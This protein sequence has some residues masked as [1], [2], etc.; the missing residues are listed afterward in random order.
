MP[1]IR[2]LLRV[3]SRVRFGIG[4]PG[5]L[6]TQLRQPSIEQLVSKDLSNEN[7]RICRPRCYRFGLSREGGRSD[8]HDEVNRRINAVIDCRDSCRLGRRHLGRS[9]FPSQGYWRYRISAPS[10]TGEP[11]L[12]RISAPNR[13]PLLSPRARRRAPYHGRTTCPELGTSGMSELNGITANPWNLERSAGGPHRRCRDGRCRHH[14]LAH[15]SDG[16]GSIRIPASWCGLFGLI[17]IPRTDFRSKTLIWSHSRICFLS[18]GARHGR[19][20]RRPF[21]PSSW[22]SVYI[23]V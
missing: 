7:E 16:G 12:Q 15:A 1:S 22:R 17:P 9:T 11:S 19:R 23:M 8:G 10:R 14:P 21:G 4:K 6:G 5:R 3:M 2:S 13:Q 20:I 18:N